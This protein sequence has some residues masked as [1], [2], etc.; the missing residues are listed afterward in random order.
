MVEIARLRLTPFGDRAEVLLSDGG[1]KFET[2]DGSQD[3][4]VATYVLDLVSE[5]DVRAVLR[6]AH[7][8]LGPAGRLCLAGLTR[9][10]SLI[11]WMVSSLW[12]H[13]HRFR[14]EWVGGCR[15][16][17]IRSFLKDRRWALQHHEIV[18]AWGVPSEILVAS[19][20]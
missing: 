2:E 14:P 15:P 16:V 1:I 13:M 4:V 20:E 17:R 10:E 5:E 11:G 3:R 6:E 8:M 18:R 7:R 19:P 12:D 9:G